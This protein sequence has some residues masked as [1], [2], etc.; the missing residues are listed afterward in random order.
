MIALLLSA[1]S[2]KFTQAPFSMYIVEPEEEDF[3]FLFALEEADEEDPEEDLEEDAEEVFEE[4]FRLESSL[5]S[6]SGLSLL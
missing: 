4:D 5:F 3:S 2:R 6:S 1:A